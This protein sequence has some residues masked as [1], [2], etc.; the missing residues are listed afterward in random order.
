[1]RIRR[2]CDQVHGHHPGYSPPSPAGVRRNGGAGDDQLHA[3]ILL[4]A[5]G[6]D[7]RRHWAVFPETMRKDSLCRN[8]LFHQISTNRLCPLLGEPLVES[9]ASD[10]IGVTFKSPS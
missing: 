1:M 10:A 6:R 5:A 7:I 8:S 3:S 9:I 4:S 2:S